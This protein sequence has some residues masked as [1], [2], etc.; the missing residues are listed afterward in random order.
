MSGHEHVPSAT[1]GES[2]GEYD[3]IL[4]TL[5]AA[6]KTFNLA[7][8]QNSIVI[9]P[10][11]KIK[12]A[13]DRFAGGIRIS[14]GNAFGYIAVQSAYEEGRPWLDELLGVIEGNYRYMRGRLEEALPEVKIADL[15]GTYLM[16]IDLSAYFDADDLKAGAMERFMEDKCRIAADYGA[17]FGGYEYAGCIRLNLATSRENVEI[18]AER[19]IGS[20]KQ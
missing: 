5:T 20:L 17:W 2:A 8:V 6:T 15:E 10:D 4:V 19:I 18:A 1:A 7:S 16:W 11:E 3:D 12:A 14:D 9:I 13:W